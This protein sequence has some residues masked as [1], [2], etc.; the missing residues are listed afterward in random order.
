MDYIQKAVGYSLSGD[1]SEQC[2]FILLGSGH[3]GK[4]TFLE[5]LRFIMNDYTAN[6]QAETIAVKN[7]FSHGINSDIA[8]LAKT[9]FITAS[10]PNEGIR[11]NEGLVKQLTGGEPVTARK[12]FENE[13]EFHPELKLWIATNHKIVIR[14]TDEGIWRR[15]RVIP[16]SVQ[17][18]PEKT[19]KHFKDKL[20]QEYPAI[21]RWAVN[22][23]LKWV[24]EGLDMPEAVLSAVREYRNEM[25]VVSRFLDDKCEPSKDARI[26]ASDLYEI[27]CVWCNENNEYIMSNTRF[28]VEVSKKFKKTHFSDGTYY[29]GI[30]QS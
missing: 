20:R 30:R 16:L 25:D 29:I 1:I 19:D 18:P 23:C 26:K 12:L 6:I 13:I 21:L 14:G 4:S 5:T 24:K 2:F 17:I 28:G 8:R 22:G 10:E 7:G 15:I 11:L 3:N 27:Y 9:R